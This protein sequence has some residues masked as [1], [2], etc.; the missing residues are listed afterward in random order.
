VKV[1]L[2]EKEKIF[3]GEKVKIFL[4][5]ELSAIRNGMAS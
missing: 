3:L 5:K 1:F 4:G 2:G